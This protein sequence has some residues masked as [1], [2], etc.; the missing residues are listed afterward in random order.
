MYYIC[1]KYVEH[2]Q[3]I[4]KT[5]VGKMLEQT[6]RCMKYVGNVRTSARHM[7]EICK[8]YVG[9]VLLI[10]KKYRKTLLPHNPARIFIWELYADVGN[11]AEMC[12]QCAGNMLEMCWD[13][14]GNCPTKPAPHIFCIFFAQVRSGIFW[15]CARNISWIF[16]AHL[17]LVHFLHLSCT[18]PAHFPHVSYIFPAHGRNACFN[19][20]QQKRTF[21]HVHIQN[22][23]PLACLKWTTLNGITC[24]MVWDPLPKVPWLRAPWLSSIGWEILP[25]RQTYVENMKHRWG[26][27]LTDGRYIWK[28]SISF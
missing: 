17:C 14:I 6:R 26:N 16:L 12:G 8:K 5:N 22:A 28:Y 10:R 27:M 20:C 4:C 19:S 15:K 2:M 18:F 13:S 1:W 25:T 11:V 7:Q 21:P 3:N 23:M 9:H 24:L